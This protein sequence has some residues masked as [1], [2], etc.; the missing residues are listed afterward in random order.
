[1][2][3]AQDIQAS[4]PGAVVELYTLDATVQGQGVFHFCP[5]TNSLGANVV[6]NGTTFTALPIQGSGWTKSTSGSAPRPTITIDNT[7]KVLQVAIIAAGDLVGAKLTRQRVFSKYLDAV[8]YARWNLFNYSAQFDNAFWT[9][10][11]TSVT[12]NVA[13]APDGTTSADSITDSSTT[14]T[15]TIA[16]TTTVTNDMKSYVFSVY[17]Q[18]TTGGTSPVMRLQLNLTGG[19]AVNTNM[20]FDSDAG[21]I[22]K[23]TAGAFGA[24]VDFG[25]FWRVSLASINN[26]TGNTSLACTLAPAAGPHNATAA[27]VATTGT[28]VIWGAQ[29]ENGSVA[30]T[31]QAT[32]TTY[33]FLSDPTQIISSE[34]Y[35]IDHKT[36]HN[37]QLVSWELV[38]P[39]DRP[40]LFLPRRQV[41]RDY[42]F[43][44]V[45]LNT[46]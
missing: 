19:T 5:M 8:N 2:T 11:S 27:N 46:Q 12:T 17:V 43:P 39:I 26:G 21:A 3:T 42:G 38:W 6:F 44:G 35:I 13:V 36:A 30:S 14:V 23:L 45:M 25:T 29:L 1:M 7:Q 18:K 4:N 33:Y 16:H 24:V 37:N 9:K 34:I 31:Y 28:A 22:T 32:T 41:L 15:G 20:F 10:T 40:G